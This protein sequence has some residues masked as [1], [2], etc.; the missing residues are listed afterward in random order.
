MPIKK[1]VQ[2]KRG[3]ELKIQF[4]S[5]PAIPKSISSVV[6]AVAPENSVTVA[7]P[8]SVTLT[9]K[10]EAPAETVSIIHLPPSARVK[11]K[12]FEVIAVKGAKKTAPCSNSA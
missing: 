10:L 11:E 12:R 3:S 1:L 7:E 2:G 9:A 6:G 8:Y 4:F 5:S